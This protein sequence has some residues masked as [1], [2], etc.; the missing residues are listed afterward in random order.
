MTGVQTCALPIYAADYGDVELSPDNARVAVSVRDQLNRDIWLFDVARGLRTRFTFDP[1]AE[2]AS[3]WSPDGSRIVFS[4]TRKGPPNLYQKP[5]TGAGAE[6][7][8]L[9][10]NS[11]KYPASWFP[12]GKS[13]LY[14]LGPG[15]FD[16]WVLPLSGD[17]KPVPF[18]KTQFN[19]PA[20]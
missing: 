19:K 4:S 8:L 7:A 6:E 18:L 15:N 16:L 14:A 20:G 1:A 11:V 12:D 9:E 17:K 3:I 13:I 10:D 5:S 2:N